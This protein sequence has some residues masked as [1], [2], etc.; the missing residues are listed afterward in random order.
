LASVDGSAVVAVQ[1]L[2]IGLSRPG[3][4][5]VDEINLSI[6]RG[7]VLGLVGESG[8]G[9]TT[10]ALSLLGYTRRGLTID[11]G[12]VLV[13]DRNLLTMKAPELRRVR[14]A[15]V[16]YVPQDP[17]SALN[18]ALTVRAQIHGVLSA[19]RDLSKR[20]ADARVEAV[21][22]DV[23]LPANSASRFPHQLSG[24]QQQRV[25]IAIAFACEP[26]VVVMDEPTTGL[27]VSLQKKVLRLLRALCH[28]Q[29]VAG[30][31]V[32]HDLAAVAS[33]ADSIAV[34]YAGRI[35]ERGRTAEV[36]EAPR[37]P[38]TQALL[39][40][41]PHLGRSDALV[42]I[43]GVQPPPGMRPS[44]C[45]FA[46]RC[47]FAVPLCSDTP[48]PDKLVNGTDHRV[49][50]HVSPPIAVA[51]SPR[52]GGRP[53]GPD[54]D[55]RAPRQCLLRVESVRAWY[56]ESVVL[57]DVSLNVMQGECVALVGESGS[58]KTTLARC[59]IGLHSRWTG[60]ISLAGQRLDRTARRRDKE[61]LRRLQYVFQ[62][63][64][65]SL[66]PRARVIDILMRPIRRF[67]LPSPQ[68]A[69]YSALDEVALSR[70][71]L[72]KYPG[73]LSGGERQRVALARALVVR[74]DVLV[75]DEVTS[76]LD[77]S[78]QAVIGELL[79][80]QQVERSLSI[81]FITHNLALAY[82]L[83]QRVV[84]LSAGALVEEGPTAAVLQQPQQEYT[85][86]LLNDVPR[87]A[88]ARLLQ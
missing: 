29:G 24:G 50:C 15:V 49:R 61:G 13:E 37:H 62:N 30:L 8:S 73:Q 25:A 66:N 38:Y 43:A 54:P 78:V 48:P 75:C 79:Q 18:P 17:G 6:E 77:V 74:P 53:P 64:Y 39:R 26:S 41:L 83:A 63:P 35:V 3:G 31:Y 7:E 67:S 65:I 33:I 4:V 56:Q 16:S 20:D 1:N 22:G 70:T 32:T 36:F 51:P 69:L 27:D 57:H 10:V 60:E 80:R 81:L 28:E 47:S 11:T 68:S 88:D 23:G 72:Y 2:G 55:S 45:A 40:A 84:V 82:A 44:G 9:K 59:I 46:P 21:L 42:G 19:H 52:A 12:K 87:I 58:G 5:V 71:T 76:A 85:R 34:V 86:Q 14:G